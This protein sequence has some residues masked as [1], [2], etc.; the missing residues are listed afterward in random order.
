MPPL[1]PL[2]F[3]GTSPT[4]QTGQQGVIT[5]R[6][7]SPY[8]VPIT[9]TLTLVFTPNLAN[10]VDDPAVQLTSGGRT[11]TFTIPTGQTEAQFSINPL[12]FQV[13]TVAGQVQLQTVFTPTGGQPTPGPTVTVTLARSIPVITSASLTAAP[14]GFTLNVEGF[15]NTREVSQMTLQFTPVAGSTLLETTAFTIPVTAAYNA[16]YSSAASLPFGGGFRFS[17]PL[18]VTGDATVIDSVV[19]RISNSVGE[20]LPVTGRR[21]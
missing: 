1:P 13:G 5:I 15:S 21:N 8:P 6:L 18:T 16:W 17:L 7:E 4:I 2:S 20:S 11:V 9:G 19:V 14:G 12:R 10:P 3:F